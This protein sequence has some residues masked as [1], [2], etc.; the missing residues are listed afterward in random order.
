M[1]REFNLK[2]GYRGYRALTRQALSMLPNNS[3]SARDVCGMVEKLPV[4]F[5][6]PQHTAS[7]GWEPVWHNF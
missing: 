2:K 3:G 7:G 5:S 4:F 6:L 1:K